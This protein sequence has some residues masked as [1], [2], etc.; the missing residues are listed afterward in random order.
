V[1]FEAQE[2]YRVAGLD[3]LYSDK[4]ERDFLEQ[5]L[6][7]NIYTA[8]LEN[9]REIEDG[10]QQ[11]ERLRAC[12]N[13]FSTSL[14]NRREHPAHRPMTELLGKARAALRRCLQRFLNLM[15]LP[16]FGHGFHR[17]SLHF[18]FLPLKPR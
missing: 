14:K 4:L 10:V 7:S 8:D 6:C 3:L 16:A 11:V 1:D 17:V 13:L 12:M 9:G 15:L 2:R 5:Q 18:S